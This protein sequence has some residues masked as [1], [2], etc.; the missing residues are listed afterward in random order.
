M[1]TNAGIMVGLVGI[2]SMP[3]Q[4]CLICITFPLETHN[5]NVSELGALKISSKELILEVNL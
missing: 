3:S 1:A 5:M 2:I 4:V